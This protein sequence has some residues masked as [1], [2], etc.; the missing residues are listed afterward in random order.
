MTLRFEEALEALERIVGELEN[1][2]LP[3]E[4]ALKLF[5]EGVKLTRRCYQLLEEAEQRIEILM[6]TEEGELSI[7]PLEKS[8]L[9]E[10]R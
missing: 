1:K 10:T 7:V 3:L 9:S 2:E 4:E 5:E 8:K 6:K